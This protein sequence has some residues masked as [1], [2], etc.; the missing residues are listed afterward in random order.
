MAEEENKYSCINVS[1]GTS[2]LYRNVYGYA[3]I[4]KLLDFIL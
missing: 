4:R 3:I 1:K 2:L